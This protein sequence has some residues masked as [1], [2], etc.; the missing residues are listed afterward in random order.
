VAARRVWRRK[1][2]FTWGFL[3]K[4]ENGCGALEL[5]LSRGFRVQAGHKTCQASGARKRAH[6]GRL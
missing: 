1:H 6:H 5:K 3:A 4:R 2:G